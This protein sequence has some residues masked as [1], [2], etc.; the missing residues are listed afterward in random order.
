MNV[1]LGME[2]GLNLL[3]GPDTMQSAAVKKG[4]LKVSCTILTVTLIL[5][6]H[7]V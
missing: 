2:M 1:S 6:M 4:M 3:R 5:R 7:V